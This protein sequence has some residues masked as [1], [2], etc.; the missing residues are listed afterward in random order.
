[1]KQEHMSHC[2]S[3]KYR[4]PQEAGDGFLTLTHGYTYLSR[5]MLMLQAAHQQLVCTGPCPE[6]VDGHGS[7]CNPEVQHV[8]CRGQYTA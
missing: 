8:V 5:T 4:K 3:C 1:M 2:V 6:A 7:I